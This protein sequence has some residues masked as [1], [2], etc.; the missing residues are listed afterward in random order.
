MTKNLRNCLKK[1]HKIYRPGFLKLRFH[2]FL[3]INYQVNFI[4]SSKI[5]QI[6]LSSVFQP[7]RLLPV[8]MVIKHVMG[9]VVITHPY[10]K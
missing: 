2:T 9:C 3:I 7:S 10:A 1:K 8:E 6:I 4:K 5:F